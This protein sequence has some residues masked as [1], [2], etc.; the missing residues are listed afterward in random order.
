MVHLTDGG[1]IEIGVT[2]GGIRGRGDGGGVFAIA[3]QEDFG[4]CPAIGAAGGFGRLTVST[5]GVA[6]RKIFGCGNDVAEAFRVLPEAEVDPALAG[7]DFANGRRGE[8]CLCVHLAGLT[9]RRRK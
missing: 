5:E 7:P 2:V 4:V 1:Q 8:L 3:S 6:A 9:G